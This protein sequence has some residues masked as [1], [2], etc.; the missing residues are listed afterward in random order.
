[1]K[2]PT[3]DSSPVSTNQ[4]ATP[5]VPASSSD[6]QALSGFGKTLQGVGSEMMDYAAEENAKA[7]S[8]VV[9][10]RIAKLNENRLKMMHN[11][12]QGTDAGLLT[13]Q[14]EEALNIS[15]NGIETFDKLYGQ[16]ME[17]LSPEQTRL[18]QQHTANERNEVLLQLNRH[19]AE[20]GKVLQTANAKALV[21]TH[22]QVL[23]TLYMDMGPE[24][25]FQYRLKQLQAAVLDQ[26]HMHGFGSDSPVAQNMVAEATSKAYENAIHQLADRQPS[27]AMEKFREVKDKLEPAAAARLEDKLKHVTIGTQALAISQ[28]LVSKYGPDKLLSDDKDGTKYHGNVKLAPFDLSGMMKQ[29]RADYPDNPDLVE[30]IRGNLIEQKA[31]H[32]Q[33]ARDQRESNTDYVYGILAKKGLKGAGEVY[34]SE[35][36]RNLSGK[37]QEA[38]RAD[39]LRKQKEIDYEARQ[40]R[41]EARAARIERKANQQ[42]AFENWLGSHDVDE[43]HN[44]SRADIQHMSHKIGTTNVNKLLAKK[45]EV[46]KNEHALA[47]DKAEELGLK[48]MMVEAGYDWAFN[49]SLGAD[50]KKTYGRLRDRV[51]DAIREEGVATGKQVTPERKKEIYREQLLKV[52]MMKNSF[53][54][55]LPLIGG[56]TSS[57]AHLF[58]ADPYNVVVEGAQQEDVAMAV[59]VLASKG[60]RHPS[61]EVIQNA[62]RALKR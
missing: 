10:G 59:S 37:D 58:E 54:G 20:Q 29:V 12:G 50:Q 1:V 60:I 34:A 47:N 52:H 32:D 8:A 35:Q 45:R 5:Q 44:M 43:L 4:L 7:N 15:Q 53:F 57:E 16:A 21:D 22:E 33:A 25:S 30:R 61:Y 49:S 28:D 26:A 46:D 62:V 2:I 14:G 39:V 31:E 51:T 3:L 17:G 27:A 38:V 56:P 36:Y 48:E 9:M 19:E 42:D 24:G 41:A 11:P 55:D 23:G 6:T 18:F 13:R 40:Q